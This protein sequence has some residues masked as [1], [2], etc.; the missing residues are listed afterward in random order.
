MSCSLVA[1]AKAGVD[2]TLDQAD[3]VQ[4]DP[5]DLDPPGISADNDAFEVS[6]KGDGISVVRYVD[7][8]TALG[9]IAA[10]LGGGSSILVNSPTHVDRRTPQPQAS[11]GAQSTHASS[12]AH[13]PQAGQSDVQDG[14]LSDS[15]TTVGE[16]ILACN[17]QRYPAKITA[18]G[19]FLQVRNGV[20]T[21]T[22]DQVKAQFRPAGETLPANFH[23]DFN[24]AISKRWVAV[25][26][27]DKDQYFVTNTGRAAMEAKFEKPAQKSAPRRRAKP[28]TE[29]EQ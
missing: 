15:R 8:D 22:K 5:V 4:P 18:I 29:S 3:D 16:F 25:S 23:R 19:H 6:V 14:M 12:G 13:G 28:K 1:N 9:V 27:D 11:S 17:A 26:P 10:V 21:F 7:Q 20:E 24:D 2:M